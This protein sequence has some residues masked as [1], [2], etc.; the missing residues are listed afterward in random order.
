MSDGTKAIR[1]AARGSGA[2]C[3]KLGK[4]AAQQ[5]AQ[6]DVQ[7]A[8]TQFRSEEAGVSVWPR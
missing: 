6:T 8:P 5:E 4:P 1:I 7:Q 2:S 3:T